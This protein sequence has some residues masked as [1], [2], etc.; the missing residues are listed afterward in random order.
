MTGNSNINTYNLLAV[1]AAAIGS[2]TFGFTVNVTGPVLGMASF[3]KYFDLN[4]NQT[5]GVIGGEIYLVRNHQT[6]PNPL[7]YSYPRMLFWWRDCRRYA[8]RLGS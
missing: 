5:T 2:F 1:L 8:G 4:I 7:P 3:Y 6:P